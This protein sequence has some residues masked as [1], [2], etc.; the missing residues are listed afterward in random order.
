[1]SFQTRTTADLVQIANA[2]GGFRLDA[3]TRTT[4]DLVMI[5]S[6]ASKHQAHITFAGMSVRTTADLVQIA[7][8]GKGAI[9][10]ED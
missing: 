2:G 1:M 3:R 5:A 6:A 8:A 10:L 4:A 9:V 7:A